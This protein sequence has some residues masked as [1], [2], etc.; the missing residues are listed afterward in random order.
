MYI[1]TSNSFFAEFF[2]TFSSFASFLLSPTLQ[3]EDA[4]RIN[5][6]TNLARSS[7]ERAVDKLHGGEGFHLMLFDK[8]F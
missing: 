2:N 5:P 8:S 7:S 1:P 6:W 3:V 4:R